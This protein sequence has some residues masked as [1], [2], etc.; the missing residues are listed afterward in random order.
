MHLK[1]K[2]QISHAKSSEDVGELRSI[3]K[4]KDSNADSIPCKRVR[5]DHVSNNNGEEAADK[6]ER[7]SPCAI[8]A[9]A[10][11]LDEE[12]LPVENASRV[13]D[14][15]LNLSRYTR[16]SFEQSSEVDEKPNIRDPMDL[17]ALVKGPKSASSGTELDI[18]SDDVLKS[19]TFIPKKKAGEIKQVDNSGDAASSQDFEVD[20]AEDNRKMK[21]AVS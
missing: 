21:A 9:N 17:L 20:Q 6:F 13:P 8:S 16:Y 19:V 18:P 14:Y 11:V 1:P 5:F 3:L 2:S 4:R 12:S 7:Y 10:M 15:L